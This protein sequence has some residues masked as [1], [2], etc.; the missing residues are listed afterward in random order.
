MDQ[1]DGH[2]TKASLRMTECE[3]RVRLSNPS[4]INALVVASKRNI[5][6]TSASRPLTESDLTRFDYLVAMDQSNI[7]DIKTAIQY[8]LQKD[9]SLKLILQKIVLMTDYCKNP[10]FK[11]LGKVP[12]PYY[13]GPAGFELV[14][15]LLTDACEGLLDDIS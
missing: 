10:K 2:I 12:D 5:T 6:I 13:G 1:A 11:A 4:P 7:D 3:K 9:S 14:L 15:D 8:W